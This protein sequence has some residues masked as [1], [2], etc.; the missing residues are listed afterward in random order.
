ML[1]FAKKEYYWST[2]NVGL[3]YTHTHTFTHTCTHTHAHAHT[4]DLSTLLWLPLWQKLQNSCSAAVPFEVPSFRNDE[5]IDATPMKRWNA[6]GNLPWALIQKF[7]LTRVH[8]QAFKNHQTSWNCQ[9]NFM[10][11]L[12]AGG[13]VQSFNCGAGKLFLSRSRQ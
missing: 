13:N 9:Q 3:L 1:Y 7:F 4:L 12:F 5:L 2:T 6:T 8:S 10:W 11:V